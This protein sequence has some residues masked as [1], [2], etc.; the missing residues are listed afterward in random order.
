M[1]SLRNRDYLKPQESALLVMMI[2]TAVIATI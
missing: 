2:I 1:G